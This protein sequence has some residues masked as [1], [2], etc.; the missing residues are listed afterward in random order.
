VPDK[1]PAP[2][3]NVVF[4]AASPGDDLAWSSWRIDV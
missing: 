1:P 2:I 3:E 4:V